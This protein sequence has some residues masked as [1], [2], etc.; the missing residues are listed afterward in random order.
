M[1][2]IDD[3]LPYLQPGLRRAPYPAL[4]QALRSAM[5]EF[6]ERSGLMRQ[7]L[8]PIDVVEGT[9]SYDLP[10]PTDH[11]IVTPVSVLYDSV[12]VH[13]TSESKADFIAPSWRTNELL[14]RYRMEGRTTV[15]LLWSPDQDITGGLIVRVSLR[16]T[17]D[18]DALDDALYRDWA[19]VLAAGAAARL[20]EM[21]GEPWSNPNAAVID[22]RK[23]GGGVAAAR[24]RAE[25]SDTAQ[26]LRMQGR[27][28]A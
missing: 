7:T 5:I 14:Y 12:P 20:R 15:K 22:A 24:V 25:A 6:C 21:P 27:P 28:F 26:P 1:S 4:A 13:P 2:S 23:F 11:N 19:E 10:E 18:A 17:R 16:P 3:F 8:D 9:A